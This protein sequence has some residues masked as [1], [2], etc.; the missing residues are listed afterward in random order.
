MSLLNFRLLYY[1]FSKTVYRNLGSQSWFDMIL[2]S[3]CDIY[4]EIQTISSVYAMSFPELEFPAQVNHHREILAF[5]S[6]TFTKL[7]FLCV[8]SAYENADSI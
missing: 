7:H 4:E 1:C 2:K 8:C 5:F 6:K 3:L